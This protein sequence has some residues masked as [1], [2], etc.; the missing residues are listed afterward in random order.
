MAQEYAKALPASVILKQLSCIGF[1]YCCKLMYIARFSGKPRG[2]LHAEVAELVD[3]HASGACILGCGGS[4]P[5]LG[6]I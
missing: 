2:T 1:D 6:T 4:S 3:A 5:L